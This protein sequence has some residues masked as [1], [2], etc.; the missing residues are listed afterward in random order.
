MWV[1]NLYLTYIIMQTLLLLSF[2]IKLVTQG[3][4][5]NIQPRSM[6]YAWRAI[7]VMENFKIKNKIF[8]E[9]GGKREAGGDDKLT[10]FYGALCQF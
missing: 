7:L 5:V 10:F 4:E 1:F 3:R 8:F 2:V 6:F 9:A